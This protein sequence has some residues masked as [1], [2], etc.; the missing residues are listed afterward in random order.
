MP[1]FMPAGQSSGTSETIDTAMSRQPTREGSVTLQYP[2][3]TRDN[4]AAWAIK[5]KVYM[6]AQGVW[7]AVEATD[8]V[9]ARQDQIALAA[10]YHGISEETLFLLAEKTTAKEAW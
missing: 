3:L 1:K 4:Y 10:I 5:M 7:D 8:G 2:L 6:C 9:D